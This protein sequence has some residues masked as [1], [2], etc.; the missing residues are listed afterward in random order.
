MHA[1][2]ILE[3]VFLL[4]GQICPNPS[5]RNVE[6]LICINNDLNLDAVLSNVRFIYSNLDSPSSFEKVEI[7][8]TILIGMM[9]KWF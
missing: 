6:L 9:E 8:I 5:R 1:D 7:D 3:C 4:L 2:R